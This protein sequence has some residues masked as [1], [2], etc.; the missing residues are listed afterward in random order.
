MV[1]NC[2]SSKSS[3]G[4]SSSSGGGSASSNSSGISGDGMYMFIRIYKSNIR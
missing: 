4:S 1:E 3:S 2:F